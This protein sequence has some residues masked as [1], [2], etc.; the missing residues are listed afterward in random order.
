MERLF[1]VFDD[2]ESLY[3]IGRVPARG[4][5][6]DVQLG[7]SDV[8]AGPYEALVHGTVDVLAAMPGVIDVWQEDREVVLVRAPGVATAALAEVVDRYWLHSL[9]RTS[10]DPSYGEV[11]PPDVSRAWSPP[12]LPAGDHVP[13]QRGPSFADVVRLPPSR[14]RMWT[15][16]VCGAVATAGGLI[17]TV[18][19]EGS[20]TVPLVLGVVNLAVG[21]GIVRQR[22]VRAD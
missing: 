5:E 1:G 9:P 15:Y 10:P 3:D 20:G 2:E 18:S 12:P 19:G 17:L 6:P 7:F 21:L 4:D 13:V 8:A 22:R 14:R 11:R 16:L